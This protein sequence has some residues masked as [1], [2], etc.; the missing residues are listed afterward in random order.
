MNE[1]K[2]Y[3]SPLLPYPAP[4]QSVPL[5]IPDDRAQFA[6]FAD[7]MKGIMDMQATKEAADWQALQRE[8][9]EEEREQAIQIRNHEFDNLL[10]QWGEV[11]PDVEDKLQFYNNG[12]FPTDYANQD[13][14]YRYLN[15]ILVPAMQLARENNER[16]TIDSLAP[17]AQYLPPD[18]Y[19][20]L[21]EQLFAEQM[22]IERQELAPLID[23]VFDTQKSPSEEQIAA[24]IVMYPA[25]GEKGVNSMVASAWKL[26]G[27]DDKVT[28]ISVGGS[29]TT[30]VSK[31]TGDE[32]QKVTY[33]TTAINTD[34]KKYGR[35]LPG[36]FINE[37]VPSDSDLGKAYAHL[38]AK[39]RERM[40]AESALPP[41]LLYEKESR[42]SSRVTITNIS[43]GYQIK[44]DK[45]YCK[46]EKDG[47]IKIWRSEKK[48]W[49]EVKGK[50]GLLPATDLTGFDYVKDLFNY[51]GKDAYNAINT[52]MIARSAANAAAVDTENKG[53]I[54]LRDTGKANP[55][56]DQKDAAKKAAGV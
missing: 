49:Q 13:L 23:H 45:K 6:Q 11:F 56:P 16:F 21:S 43:G 42:L 8:R 50:R 55:S 40:S 38:L 5:I 27:R 46:I 17:H 20:G 34:L 44:K 30:V 51:G 15:E 36:G 31:D 10:N 28:N 52:Y 54:W 37:V 53:K 18:V 47:T 25:L 33:N 24:W 22:D 41:S 4:Q 39:D 29:K 19:K 35:G 32:F 1:R 3:S 12:G 2:E 14:Q 48:K 9:S 7:A 26:H